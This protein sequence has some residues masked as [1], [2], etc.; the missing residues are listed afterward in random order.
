[1]TRKGILVCRSFWE[2]RRKTMISMLFGG[3][4]T[5]GLFCSICIYGCCARKKNIHIHYGAYSSLLR[6]VS[7]TVNGTCL[8][9]ITVRS[10]SD[11]GPSSVYVYSIWLSLI[12]LGT[13]PIQCYLQYRTS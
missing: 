7:S 13:K 5:Y 8:L 4:S 11:A 10:Y 9:T 6:T 3:A 1:M 2:L 12:H